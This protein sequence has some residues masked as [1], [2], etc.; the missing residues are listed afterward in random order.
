MGHSSQGN[1]H[2]SQTYPSPPK[3]PT[4]QVYPS[5]SMPSHL[6]AALTTAQSQNLLKPLPD[7]ST[8]L[9]CSM[10]HTGR[11]NLSPPLK[12]CSDP[13]PGL[14]PTPLFL[15]S[16]LRHLSD[17]VILL[18]KA[19]QELPWGQHASQ[20]GKAFLPTTTANAPAPESIIL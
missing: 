10:P 13:Q 18:F 1:T 20:L 17:L 12:G 6:G 4:S 2:T 19:F 11:S 8:C 3:R 5:S 7:Q 15:Q 14:T 16:F 9:P